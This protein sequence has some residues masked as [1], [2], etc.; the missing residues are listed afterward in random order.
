MLLVS[1]Q[2]LL[3]P[4]VILVSKKIALGDAEG[5]LDQYLLI[6]DGIIKR[7]DKSAS[8]RGIRYLF[9]SS[10]QEKF[11]QSAATHLTAP[12]SHAKFWR[13]SAL[14]ESTLKFSSS[15]SC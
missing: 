9:V 3:E 11:L 5:T 13:D 15:L 7:R 6:G 14:V 1:F 10:S 2:R 8:R 12:A 4:L